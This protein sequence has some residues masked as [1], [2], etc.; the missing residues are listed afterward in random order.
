MEREEIE[1]LSRHVSIQNQVL[2]EILEATREAVPLI[3]L[4][5]GIL[6]LVF[7]AMLYALYKQS[8]GLSSMADRSESVERAQTN[9]S[10]LLRNYGDKIIESNMR[11][12]TSIEEIRGIKIGKNSQH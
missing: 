12:E 2:L 9:M 6:V 4:F 3:L 11:I 7:G 5:F 10:L 1:L 8:V